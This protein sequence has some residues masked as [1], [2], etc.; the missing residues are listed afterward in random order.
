MSV[1]GWSTAPFLIAIGDAFKIPAPDRL[2]AD[3]FAHKID[4]HLFFVKI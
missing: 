3:R 1:A 2:H 4:W